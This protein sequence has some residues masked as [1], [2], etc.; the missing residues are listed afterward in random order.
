M[1]DILKN[2]IKEEKSLNYITQNYPSLIHLANA[3]ESELMG[4]P[5][6]GKSRAKEIKAIFDLS[7]ELLIPDKDK[8]YFIRSPQDAFE[9]VKEIALYE[10]EVVSA[11]YLNTKNMIIDYRKIFIGTLNSCTLHPREV[12]GP[13]VSLRAASVLVFHNHPSMVCEPS[14]E[15]INVAKRLYEAGKV[16]GIDFIDSLIISVNGFCSLRER[17]LI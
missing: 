14:P 6:I 13:G 10:Q 12:F 1:R 4:I 5:G 7:K 15:D 16:V 8:T 2:I 3:S 9:Y 11:V 17:G